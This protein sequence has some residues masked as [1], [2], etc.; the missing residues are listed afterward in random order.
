MINIIVFVNYFVL[1]LGTPEPADIEQL[2]IVFNL[3]FNPR[4]VAALPSWEGVPSQWEALEPQRRNK[5]PQRHAQKHK[6][7]LRSY[8]GVWND[9]ESAFT[10]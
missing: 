8:A 2:R 6:P 1:V 5:D 4:L 7:S 3:K 10:T 9:L